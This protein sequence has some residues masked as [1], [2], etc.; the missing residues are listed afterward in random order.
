METYF[1]STYRW[2]DQESVRT[3]ISCPSTGDRAC[4]PDPPS[5]EMGTCTHLLWSWGAYVSALQVPVVDSEPPC[6]PSALR[7]A[8]RSFIRISQL[9]ICLLCLGAI[10]KTTKFSSTSYAGWVTAHGS[11]IKHR[12][13]FPGSE[14]LSLKTF[15]FLRKETVSLVIR[16]LSGQIRWP[17]Q[18]SSVRSL[19]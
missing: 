4:Q 7:A 18:Q 10:L 5:V 15:F 3:P 14:S 13:A 6:L 16:S 12:E 2:W 8:I 9:G 19:K 1:L 11:K 17:K